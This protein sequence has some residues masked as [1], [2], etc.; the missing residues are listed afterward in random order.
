MLPEDWEYNKKYVKWEIN[1]QKK[2]SLDFS[3]ISLKVNLLWK[4]SDLKTV[5]TAFKKN[6]IKIMTTV[7]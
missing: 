7:S 5:S 1:W 4:P 6:T 3:L 2:K